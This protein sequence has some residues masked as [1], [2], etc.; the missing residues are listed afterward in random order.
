MLPRL[1]FLALVALSIT[2]LLLSELLDLF[3]VVESICDLE[4]DL[5]TL[6]SIVVLL[7]ALLT[8]NLC[9]LTILV[10]LL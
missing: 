4:G 6:L 2:L 8:F 9:L 10:G 3:F 5:F 1:A 7:A